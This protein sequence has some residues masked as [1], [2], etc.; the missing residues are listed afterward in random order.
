MTTEKPHLLVFNANSNMVRAPVLWPKGGQF[1]PGSVREVVE[2]HSWARHLNP[3]LVPQ[4]A[5]QQCI[6]S[7]SAVMMVKPQCVLQYSLNSPHHCSICLHFYSLASYEQRPTH[8]HTINSSC[9]TPPNNVS[10]VPVK[11]HSYSTVLLMWKL[12]WQ[13]AVLC[14]SISGI[15]STTSSA[16]VTGLNNNTKLTNVISYKG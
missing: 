11:W 5:Q 8:Y 14:T 3:S 10:L 15:N 16:S 2:H 4:V 13:H 9:W 7:L 12:A 1:D 6:H